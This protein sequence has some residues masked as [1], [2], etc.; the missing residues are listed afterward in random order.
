MKDK[1][2]LGRIQYSFFEQNFR[3]YKHPHTLLDFTE[4]QLKKAIM[5]S[6]RL[7]LCQDY[8]NW[9]NTQNLTQ[10]V[11]QP[12]IVFYIANNPIL[13]VESIYPKK[14]KHLLMIYYLVVN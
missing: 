3:K 5:G 11:K 10:L 7:L 14:I 12:K 13:W 8:E 6:D 2:C 1:G 4:Y 9:T